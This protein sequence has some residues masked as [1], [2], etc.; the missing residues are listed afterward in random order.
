MTSQ[1]APGRNGAGEPVLGLGGCVDYELRV[2]GSELT[3]LV[4]RYGIT[5]DE[6]DRPVRISTERDLV[7]S[8]LGYLAR[9]GGGEHHVDSLDVLEAFATRFDHRITLGGTSVRAGLAMSRLGVPSRL[10]LVC[11][12]EHF[13]RLLPP[14][15]SYVSSG[16]DGAVFPHLIVQYDAGTSVDVGDSVLTAPFPNRLIYVNDPANETMA[17]RDDLGTILSSTT[18]FLVAGLNAIADEDVLGERLLTVR[19]HMRRLPADALVYYEDAGFHHPG[20]NQRVL[21]T[22]L[23]AIHI[24]G[25]NEDELQSYLGRSVD[26][27]SAADMVTALDS[28]RSLIPVP[29]LVLHTKY[30]AAAVGADAARFA[31]ALNGGLIAATTR[32]RCGDDFTDAD[33]TATAGT[34]RRAAA[35]RFAVELE[36]AT[37]GFACCR[38][39]F[40]VNVVA[41]TTVGLGDTFVGGFLAALAR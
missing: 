8:I 7:V 13:A 6:L 1:V 4:D 17:I 10:H 26:L 40:E 35:A 18:M 12:N 30:W 24:Y 38:P 27:C 3:Q 33:L 34:P 2:S 20:F 23:D 29:T 41:P 22:L 39:A 16:F 14:D 37:D 28:L 36:Q 31:D 32:Y 25:L 9:G 21:G 11:F 19:E 5:P 15:V